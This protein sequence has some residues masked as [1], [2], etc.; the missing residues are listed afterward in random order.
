MALQTGRGLGAG[1]LFGRGYVLQK[2]RALLVT[3]T[4]SSVTGYLALWIGNV[5]AGNLL[6][7]EA[8]ASIALVAP[9][10]TLMAF[11][12]LL[13]ASGA[14]TLMAMASGAGDKDAVDRVF[15]EG[16]L[17]AVMAG[18]LLC[19]AS[20]LLREP[21]LTMFGA[22]GPERAGARAYLANLSLYALCMP[23]ESLLFV[24]LLN[25]GDN[26]RVN[27][28]IGVQLAVVA[29]L[30]VALSGRLGIG[31]ISLS[32]AI[33]CALNILLL[34]THF[35]KKGGSIRF[36]PGARFRPKEALR[37]FKF[38]ASD[39][40]GPLLVSLSTLVLNRILL[41]TFGSGALVTFSV[42][43]NL[44]TVVVTGFDG[45]GAAIQPMIGVFY[46]EQSAGGLKRTMRLA[47][48][49]AI[50]ES[51]AATVLVLL[52]AGRLPAL[53]GITDP[54]LVD[55]TA[56]AA[57]LFALSFLP[58]GLNLLYSSYYMYIDRV[59]LAL[60]NALLRSFALLQLMA[61]LLALLN[62]QPVFFLAFPIAECLALLDTLLLARWFAGRGRKRKRERE[63]EGGGLTVP[64][65][66]DAAEAARSAVFDC[67][68]DAENVM[69]M[70]GEAE[71]FLS[72][73]GVERRA[74]LR[75]LLT[76]EE[77]GMSV[78]ERNPGGRTNLFC[79]L[80][81]SDD[82]V[83]LIFRDDGAPCDAADLS[84]VSGAAAEA[85]RTRLIADSGQRN[86][87]GRI[88]GDNRT[89]F[90]F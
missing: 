67:P 64:L 34:S 27:I 69:R 32:P 57:R 4:V 51:A 20:V 25:D 40:C 76:V 1:R 90:L 42:I 81:L 54:A 8:L 5:T 55:S 58:A 78:A 21:L 28:G 17:L 47:K 9:F 88:I 33:A 73:H 65:L 22:A 14:A 74:M 46:G 71:A 16:L 68:A 85:A 39:A 80:S 70:R 37:I 11:C 52:L 60:A 83:R 45:V 63:R 50:A 35:Y 24:T 44:E 23:V 84:A 18:A 59:P 48:R 43:V 79:D 61:L 19:V 6:G 75:I 38:S 36:V 89:V 13:V 53:Y 29:V 7:E 12:S 31:A 3:G 62:R 10:H 15:S 86:E 87:Y 77:Y 49:V 56:H 72:G 82:G 30:D 41:R 66:L 26:R 2:F